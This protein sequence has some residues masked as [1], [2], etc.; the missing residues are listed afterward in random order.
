MYDRSYHPDDYGWD[1]CEASNNNIYFLGTTPVIGTPN[2]N[3]IIKINK[4]GD[5]IW[6]KV[7]ERPDDGVAIT[8]SGDGGCVITGYSE[9]DSGAYALK[10]DSVG[11][12]VWR[13]YYGGAY[14]K[15]S[16]I[17]RTSDN[18]YIACGYSN[19]FKG[20]ILKIDSNGNIKWQ[21]EYIAGFLKEFN[22]IVEAHD[23]GYI[24]AGE[25]SDSNFDSLKALIMK[26]DTGGTILWE[27]KFRIYNK[28]TS[29]ATIAKISD[30]YFVT[31]NTQDTI[32]NPYVESIA[33]FSRTDINGNLLFTKA[34]SSDKTEI[35][36]YASVINSNKFVFSIFGYH[37][38]ILDSSYAEMWLTDSIGN[39]LSSKTITSINLAIFETILPLPNGDLVFIGTADFVQFG[40]HD[41]IYAVR[42][43]SNLNFPPYIIGIKQLSNETPKYFNL[44]QNY[45]NPFNP[46]TKIKFNIPPLRG[47]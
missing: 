26:I 24:A 39:I 23:G 5:T 32:S 37:A 18:G 34:Y 25:Y 19:S 44:F 20:Y 31:G 42:T 3:Y 45:P 47:E 11:N 15:C 14:I 43:D 10:L 16:D 38:G 2:A 4:Y 8:S 1:I 41:D 9:S 27:K 13:K 7:I 6:T 22:S 29:I 40:G 12:I 33:Y 30:G 28:N 35:C 21:R 17:V 46:T 36:K